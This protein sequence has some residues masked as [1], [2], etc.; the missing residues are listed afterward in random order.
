MQTYTVLAVSR[1]L[2][3]LP[4]SRDLVKETDSEVLCSLVRKWVGQGSKAS[5]A[6]T[7]DADILGYII[8]K[9]RAGI[10]AKAKTFLINDDLVCLLPCGKLWSIL[11][12]K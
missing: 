3:T 9:L 12:I 10:L 5:L 7:A 11:E 2:V 1:D 8:G 6:D 4:V